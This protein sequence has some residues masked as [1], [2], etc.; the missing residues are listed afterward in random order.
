MYAFSFRDPFDSDGAKTKL[1][2][3]QIT[4]QA[5]RP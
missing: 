2:R 1:D 4:Q 3:T 5:R